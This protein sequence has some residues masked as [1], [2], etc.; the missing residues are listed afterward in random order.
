MP[1]DKVAEHV[2]AFA[3]LCVIVLSSGGLIWRM[4]KQSSDTQ[5]RMVKGFMETQDSY[6][7]QMGEISGTCHQ[8]HKDVADETAGAVRENT[9][10]LGKLYDSQHEI[11]LVLAET[12]AVLKTANGNM[13]RRRGFFR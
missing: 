9:K 13:N 11:K 7:K 12:T 1:W 10:V 2:P 4:V 5:A 3:A 6:M 8:S